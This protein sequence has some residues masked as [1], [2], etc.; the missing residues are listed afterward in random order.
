MSTNQKIQSI[1][2]QVR[3]E[4]A[5]R[6]ME[7]PADQPDVRW[8]VTPDPDTAGAIRVEFEARVVNP[9]QGFEDDW[10]WADCIVIG[11]RARRIC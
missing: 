6:M 7:H 11:P 3:D 10:S 4:I 2:H 1:I 5:G 9:D 8:T